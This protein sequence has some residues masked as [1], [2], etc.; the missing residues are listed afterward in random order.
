MKDLKTLI[1]VVNQRFSLIIVLISPQNLQDWVFDF[2]WVFQ[3]E[4]EKVAM[5]LLIGILKHALLLARLL[6]LKV[7]IEALKFVAEFFSVR[8]LLSE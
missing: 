1:N 3:H 6:V 5:I 7:M 8:Q 2:C 4:I